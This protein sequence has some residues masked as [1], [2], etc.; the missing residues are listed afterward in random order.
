[1]L[2]PLHENLIVSRDKV[3]EVTSGGIVL[4]ESVK[5]REKPQTATVVAVSDK[6]ADQ[7]SAGDRIL[8]P[9]YS[10]FPVVDAGMEF[11]IISLSEVIAKMDLSSKGV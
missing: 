6:L 5:E 9:K 4:P 1:M 8:I 11:T 3:A 2:K 7:F 10:G